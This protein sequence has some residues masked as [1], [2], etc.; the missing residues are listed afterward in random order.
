MDQIVRKLIRKYNTRNP[1]ELARILKIAIITEP[2]GSVRGY[3]HR[4]FRQKFI[5]INCELSDRKQLVVCAHELG[6]AILH[7][8]ANTPFMRSN[9]LYSINRHEKEANLFAADLLIDE[10]VLQEYRDFTVSQMAALLGLPVALVKMKIAL[11]K[12]E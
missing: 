10:A 1:F 8:N 3:Y 12:K 9:T 4:L 6:H 2:L 5:H 7:P 11:L